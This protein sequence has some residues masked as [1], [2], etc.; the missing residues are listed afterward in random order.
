MGNSY[1]G[2]RIDQGVPQRIGTNQTRKR[3]FQ[4]FVYHFRQNLRRP[5]QLRKIDPNP[6]GVSP[7][8]DNS[9]KTKSPEIRKKN[10]LIPN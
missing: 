2:G 3:S 9:V 6:E 10:P 5:Q 1:F 8:S 7:V 4:V